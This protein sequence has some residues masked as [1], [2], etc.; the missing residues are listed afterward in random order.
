[1]D[2]AECEGDGLAIG[3]ARFPC[4]HAHVD[5]IAFD[6]AA[7]GEQDAADDCRS[8]GSGIEVGAALEAMAGVGVQTVTARGAAYGH[9]LEPC[10][11]DEDVFGVGRDHR[12]PAAHDASE[13]ERLDVVGDDEVFGIESALDAVERLELLAF[14]GAANDDAA[15]DLVEVEGVGGLAHG[16]PCE[17]GGV[18]GVGDLLLLEQAEVGG[19]FS[20]GEPVAGVADGDATQNAGGEAAAG[21]FG[22]DLDRKMDWRPGSC[23]GNVTSSGL[24]ATP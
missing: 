20:A 24:S 9:G 13:A 18:D 8:D 7:V 22:F 21:V 5:E 4:R 6:S 10:G 11:F 17:V 23:S 19:D 3:G 2:F 14:A 12:V 16:E 15:F 1:M